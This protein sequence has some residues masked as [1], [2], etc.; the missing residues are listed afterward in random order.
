MTPPND[1]DPPKQRQLRIAS[2]AAHATRGLVRDQNTRRKTM[3]VIV[4]LA[5]V[6]LFV[7]ATFLSP[8]LDPRLRLG[9]F[10]FYWLACAWI[11]MTAVLLAIFDLLLVRAQAR[12]EKRSLAQQIAR[13]VDPG[14]GD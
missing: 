4:L 6:M 5:V 9:W 1:E 8:G 14:D 13:S 7:G 11:T 10:I 3:F 12:E 2:F